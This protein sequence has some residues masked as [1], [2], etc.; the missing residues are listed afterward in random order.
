MNIRLLLAATV[1]SGVFFSSAH[2][3]LACPFSQFNRTGTHTADGTPTLNAPG[4]FDANKLGLMGASLVAVLAAGGLAIR[5]V[6]KSA[7]EPQSFG[8][9]RLGTSSESQ[10]APLQPDA[11]APAQDDFA[12]STFAIPVP[13]EA[14]TPA[15]Q[16]AERE[17]DRVG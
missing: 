5:R 7:P 3:A 17:I 9:D 1:T 15:S 16:D 6:G 4:Q 2:G 14:L 10:A 11:P 13:L 8:A 12:V